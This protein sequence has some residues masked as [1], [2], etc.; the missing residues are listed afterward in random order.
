VAFRARGAY[1]AF[2]FIDTAAQLAEL[3]VLAVALFAFGQM[4]ALAW[5]LV[6]V[7]LAVLAGLMIDLWS[8]DQWLLGKGDTSVRLLIREILGRSIGLVIFPVAH[9]IQYQGVVILFGSAFGPAEVV[10]Y[11]SLRTFS[12]LGDV[13]LNTYHNIAQNEVAYEAGALNK[14][15]LKKIITLG[16][17]GCVAS[18]GLFLMAILWV[19]PYIFS[20]W[21]SGKVPF[22]YGIFH[23]ILLITVVR[24]AYAPAAAILSGINETLSISI[25]FLVSTVT[26]LGLGIFVSRYTNDLPTVLAC[27]SLGEVALLIGVWWFALSHLGLTFSGWLHSSWD[28]RHEYGEFVR[29]N[30]KR[31]SLRC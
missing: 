21:L 29:T 1:G 6:I 26:A 22:D 15:G 10:T 14:E 24:A 5:S 7:R 20:K 23:V 16:L 4:V 25:V 18:M 31:W 2:T 27:A 28:D 8:Q 12:R 11:V 19:G 9:S 30:M 17:A 13:L 3:V